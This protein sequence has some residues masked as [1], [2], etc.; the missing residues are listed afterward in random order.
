MIDAELMDRKILRNP[1]GL[2]LVRDRPEKRLK[3]VFD[4]F[5]I[6]KSEL[7]FGG[8]KIKRF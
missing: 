3:I 7:L 8:G 5:I 1:N 6:T 4:V 2:E